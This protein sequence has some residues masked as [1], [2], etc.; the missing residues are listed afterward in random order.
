MDKQEQPWV[1]SAK[2]LLF[3]R[4]VLVRST[5]GLLVMALLARPLYICYRIVAALSW[6]RELAIKEERYALLYSTN[7]DAVLAGAKEMLQEGYVYR[8][9][10]EW[11][12]P[13]KHSPDPKDPRLPVSIKL[14]SPRHIIMAPDYVQFEMG[15]GNCFWGLI[16]SMRNDFDP[17]AAVGPWVRRK[18]RDGLWYYASDDRLPGRRPDSDLG[19]GKVATN[20]EWR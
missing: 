16:A 18:L 1:R 8:P 17:D 19:K 9:D 5:I 11:F 2:R 20:P 13:S 10:P 12:P 3:S 14:L 6:E 7:H 4:R 15:G